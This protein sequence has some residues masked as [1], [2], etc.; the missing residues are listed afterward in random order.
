MF[1]IDLDPLIAWSRQIQELGDKGDRAAEE[2]DEAA[3]QKDYLAPDMG[4]AGVSLGVYEKV[5]YHGEKVLGSIA[6]LTSPHS[7]A[8]GVSRPNRQPS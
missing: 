7:S 4:M 5:R 2:Y 8:N 3:R 6:T 1:D